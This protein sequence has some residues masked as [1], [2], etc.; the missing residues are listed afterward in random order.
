MELSEGEERLSRRM[1]GP[2]HHQRKR[3][4][5][6]NLRHAE[7]DRDHYSDGDNNNKNSNDTNETADDDRTQS[8][9]ADSDGGQSEKDSAIAPHPCFALLHAEVGICCYVLFLFFFI[10]ITV[11]CVLLL[12]L[13]RSVWVLRKI[14]MFTFVLSIA[15]CRLEYL[16][17][18]CQNRKRTLEKHIS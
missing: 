5:A 4:E 17:R 3:K 15:L 2:R 12:L 8:A 11:V 18:L 14:F 13:Q 1:N 9:A 10:R 6:N 16:K 7:E